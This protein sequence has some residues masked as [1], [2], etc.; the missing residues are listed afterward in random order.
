V[1]GNGTAG[2]TRCGAGA[3]MEFNAVLDRESRPE[4]LN[5]R[6]LERKLEE[7][8]GLHLSW[9]APCWLTLARITE[10]TLLCAGTYADNGEFAAAGDLLVNPRLI[11]IHVR[12]EREPLVKERRGSVVAQLCHRAPPAGGM[13]EWLK[14]NTWVEIAKEPLLP[15]LH[16]RLVQ[17][18]L[19]Y[20]SYLD[21]VDQRMRRVAEAIIS[22]ASLH[23]LQRRHVPEHPDYLTFGEH[24]FR[25]ANL[26]RFERGLFLELGEEIRRI[27]HDGACASRFLADS[28][29]RSLLEPLQGGADSITARRCAT[30][31]PTPGSLSSEPGR[32][33]PG[34]V[35]PSACLAPSSR[36]WPTYPGESRCG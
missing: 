2:D 29:A 5:E 7:L 19:L 36:S 13:V 16:R 24:E 9:G 26:C 17:S 15:H 1:A 23:L 28:T 30:T 27:D 25:T 34:S 33:R 35:S 22:L 12:G 6:F 10:L 32:R 20:K 3:L 14:S 11:L 21:S 4:N 18:Q 31:P 8:D